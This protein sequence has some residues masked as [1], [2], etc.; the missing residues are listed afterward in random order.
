MRNLCE[1]PFGTHAPGPLPRL[2]IDLCQG[3]P[4]TSL[5]RRL[6][7]WLRRLA[8][9][10]Q[11]KVFD[12]TVRGIRLRLYPADNVGE[13][14]FLF[15]PQFFDPAEM[16]LLA[17]RLPHDGTFVDIGANVGLYTLNAARHLGPG[18]RVLAVEPGPEA[19]RR[20]RFNLALNPTLASITLA[21]CAIGAEEGV[22]SLH[23]DASNLGGSSLVRD[24]GGASTPVRVRPLLDVLNEAGITRIDV[25]KIDIE[26]AEDQALLPF[27]QR[28]PESLWPRLIIIERSEDSWGQDLLGRFKEAGYASVADSR[29][30]W[31]FER[32]G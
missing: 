16:A 15:M 30:N 9:L 5:G 29:M 12:A 1:A 13:R 25:L 24:H 18:G 6:A 22:L 10:A 17:E 32:I 27:F 19:G 4:V 20:L 7:L 26:G 8:M 31:L 23:M 14:K 21:D 28:A 11:G 2:L 3:M